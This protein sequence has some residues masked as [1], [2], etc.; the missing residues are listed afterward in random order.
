MNDVIGYQRADELLFY[1]K[2]EFKLCKADLPASHKLFI[3]ETL[4]KLEIKSC[5]AFHQKLSLPCNRVAKLG[6]AKCNG[7][8]L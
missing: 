7:C 2:D 3:R 6:H 1:I 4:A 5:Y 8:V